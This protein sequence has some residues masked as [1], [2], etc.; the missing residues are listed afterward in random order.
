MQTTNVRGKNKVLH[1]WWN[2]SLLF[3]EPWQSSL[4]TLTDLHDVGEV[5]ALVGQLDRHSTLFS[6]R[7]IVP[8]C[9]HLF[10][11]LTDYQQMILILLVRSQ[12]CLIGAAQV[13]LLSLR[14]LFK[15][16]FLSV[17]D[18]AGELGRLFGETFAWILARVNVVFLDERSI[19]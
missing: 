16:L 11:L 5:G 17:E 7:R 18:A 14:Q 1:H 6:L 9:K 4:F 13:S 2:F 8:P 10:V 19:L 15:I 12:E 3:S